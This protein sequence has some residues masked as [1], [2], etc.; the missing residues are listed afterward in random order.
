MSMATTPLAG[1]VAMQTPWSGSAVHHEVI[2]AASVV[3]SSCQ[4][5]RPAG[6]FWPGGMGAT[7]QPREA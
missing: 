7:R 6:C 3:A 4:R 1:P 5:D 2:V